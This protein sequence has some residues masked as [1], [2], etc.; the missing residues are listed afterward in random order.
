[1]Q[2]DEIKHNLCYIYTINVNFS[3]KRNKNKFFK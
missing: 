2:K 1:M 3:L